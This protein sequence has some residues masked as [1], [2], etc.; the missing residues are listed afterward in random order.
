MPILEISLV[1][2]WFF[3]N[4]WIVDTKNKNFQIQLDNPH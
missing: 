2:F 4:L 3:Q 1:E